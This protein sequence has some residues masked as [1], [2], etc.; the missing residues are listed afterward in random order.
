V[1]EH[2]DKIKEF[3]STDGGLTHPLP[4]KQFMTWREEA[5]AHYAHEQTSLIP[6]V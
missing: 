6:G 5:D 4:S 3:Y 2:V 1:P